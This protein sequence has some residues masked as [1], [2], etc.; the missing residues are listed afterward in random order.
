MVKIMIFVVIAIHLVFHFSVY[1]QGQ[2]SKTISTNKN[3]NMH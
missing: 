1:N 3:K 2:N